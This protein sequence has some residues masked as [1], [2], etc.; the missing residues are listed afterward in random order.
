MNPKTPDKREFQPQR[1]LLFAITDAQKCRCCQREISFTQPMTSR[2][3]TSGGRPPKDEDDKRS[4]KMQTHFTPDNAA[5]IDGKCALAGLTR[6]EYLREL[7]LDHEV[8]GEARPDELKRLRAEIGSIGG[9]I[10]Q[11]AKK[12][13]QGEV[14]NLRETDFRALIEYLYH[15]LEEL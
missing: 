5:W 2:K 9:N 10:N 4:V 6:A 11:I 3:S 15:K 13:N 12:V 14:D 8:S 1:N 7:A